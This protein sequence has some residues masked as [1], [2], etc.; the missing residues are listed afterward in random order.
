MP[1][2]QDTPQLIYERMFE[3][4]EDSEFDYFETR[5][6]GFYP[7]ADNLVSPNLYPWAFIEEGGMSD[8]EVIRFPMVWEYNYTVILIAMTCADRGDPTSLVFND[9]TNEK[10][11]IGDIRQDIGGKYWEHKIDF[12]VAGNSLRD[13]RIT[14]V[15]NTPSI[16]NIQRLLVHP[17]I[18]GIQFDFVFQIN[19]RGI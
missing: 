12:G 13:W 18:R 4:L 11:G 19:E 1:I 3:I 15:S 9:G 8:I 16:L 5:Q 10:K 17:F 2:Y 14:R 6:K 7:R